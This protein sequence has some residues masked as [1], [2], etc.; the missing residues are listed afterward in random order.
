MVNWGM[1]D[2]YLHEG[3][4]SVNIWQYIGYVRSLG[5]TEE[6]VAGCGRAPPILTTC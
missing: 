4:Y 1:P 6:Y 5:S 2:R 3:D